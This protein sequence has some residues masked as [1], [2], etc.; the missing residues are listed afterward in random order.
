MT[1]AWTPD[2]WK[3]FPA[4]QQP[5]YPDLN[6]LKDALGQLLKL[7]PLVT[8]WEIDHLR[9]GLAAAQR[10]EAWLLQGGD[11]AETFGEC[12]TEM[13]ASKLKLLLQMSLVIVFASRKRIVRVG[14]IAG[15]YAKPRSNDTESIDGIQ[16]PCY[17]G[18]IVNQF[19]FSEKARRPDP[20]R[21][22]RGYERSALTLNFI[23][24]LSEGGFADLHHPENWNLLFVNEAKGEVAKRYRELV[25]SLG[26]A[27]RFMETILEG[28]T[29][30]ELKRVDFF[31][32]HEA[33][34]LDYEMA[35]TR[36]SV[37]GIG[38][39]NMGTH[40]PWIGE[41]TRSLQGAHVEYFRGIRNPI[42]VKIGPSISTDE[43]VELIERLNPED[44]PGRLTLI[45]RM[46][47]RFVESKLPPLIE[48]VNRSGKSVLW[49]CDP[50]HGNT[51]SATQGRK[52]RR[53]DDIV[54]ELRLSFAIHHACGSMLGGAHLELTGE[55]VTE[56]TGGS[57]G[58][59]DSDLES[60]YQTQV[61]PRLNY[62][63]AL[64]MAFEIAGKLVEYRAP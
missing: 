11:C 47:R 60:A 51:V 48:A 10:G 43:L 24:A 55:N 61:D 22:L 2:S 7:P 12:Q 27:L 14:R 15:Q 46:G 19:E 33:L 57:R 32:S 25:K 30:S 49:V 40:F 50:M 37:R 64:E 28:S 41:R 31:T 9:D 20:N 42:G 34:L 39:Y 21:L 18:D 54:D 56:C 44:E 6:E 17:R 36:P 1:A 23:R 58:I 13:I 5:N 53:F 35:L 3:Q 29:V 26:D 63:Q 62:E 16:L 52:T 8:S 45:H 59:T 4:A 38:Y